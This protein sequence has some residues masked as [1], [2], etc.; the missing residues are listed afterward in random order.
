M[1]MAR[2]PPNAIEAPRDGDLRPSI[3]T[4][5][6]DHRDRPYASARPHPSPTS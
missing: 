6:R 1:R 4:I 2:L 5:G 3:R